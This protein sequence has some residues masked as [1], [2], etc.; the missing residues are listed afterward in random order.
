MKPI[1][2]YLLI[3][4]TIMLGLLCMIFL[5]FYIYDLVWNKNIQLDFF[6][7]TPEN[8]SLS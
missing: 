5:P 3:A 2:G 4:G 8:G 6:A 7:P 1:F